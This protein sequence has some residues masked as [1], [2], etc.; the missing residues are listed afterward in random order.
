M[1]ICYTAAGAEPFEFPIAAYFGSRDR[2][3]TQQMV[4][5][6][7]AF[8]TGAFTLKRIEGHHLWPLDKKGKRVWLLSVV[9]VLLDM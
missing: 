3:I 1:I 8:T 4:H 7:G 5:G 6:W 2:R 9:D